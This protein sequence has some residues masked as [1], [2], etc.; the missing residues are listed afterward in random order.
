MAC[1]T[2]Y[3]SVQVALPVVHCPVLE[4]QVAPWLQS[5]LLTQW[6][7]QAPAALSQ[8]YGA[9]FL[10]AGSAQEPLPSQ[11][12]G[13]C[14]TS[15][16]HWPGWQATALLGLV[17]AVGF[18]PSHWPLHTPLPAQSVRGARGVPVTTLQAPTLPISAQAWHWALHG[19]SQQTWSTQ[20]PLLHWFAAAHP[21]P[22]SIFET[23][24]PPVQ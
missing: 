17:H 21:L 2:V 22:L 12:P 13:G 18:A 3:A 8:P 10:V 11:A 5:V 15:P 7:L 14:A 16:V 20:N 24:K 4:S 1:F 6:V 23:Q 19:E 9:Q